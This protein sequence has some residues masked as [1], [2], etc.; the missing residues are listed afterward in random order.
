MKSEITTQESLSICIIFLA[1]IF[2]SIHFFHALARLESFFT[3]F[4]FF[5]LI[6]AN[7]FGF[8]SFSLMFWDKCKE[9]AAQ[10][11]QGESNER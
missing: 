2:W 9:L 4:C 10:Q 1:N 11:K 5:L 6:L 3:I 7:I 8:I